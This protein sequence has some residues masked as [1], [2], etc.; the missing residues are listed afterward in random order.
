[1]NVKALM[2]IDLLPRSSFGTQEM[3]WFNF[4]TLQLFG[5]S[6]FDSF[7]VCYCYSIFSTSVWCCYTQAFS[8]CHYKLCLLLFSAEH[9]NLLMF[10]LE[11][12]TFQSVSG[13]AFSAS[14]PLMLSVSPVCGRLLLFLFLITQVQRHLHRTFCGTVLLNQSTPKVC[15]E[16][17]ILIDWLASKRLFFHFTQKLHKGRSCWCDPKTK[18]ETGEQ[19]N[20]IT[21]LELSLFSFYLHVR[22]LSLEP[23]C[24]KSLF[25]FLFNIW[26]FSEMSCALTP[27]LTC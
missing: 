16:D 1:M 9:L 25:L 26:A 17:H 5:V 11:P 20:Q 13:A 18:V 6:C 12:S 8:C 19:N 23:L 4:K 2:L 15:R 14:F 24:C 27:P 21:N 7:F 10:R 22:V 3:Q